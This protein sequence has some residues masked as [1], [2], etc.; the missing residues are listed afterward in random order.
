MDNFERKINKLIK[1][2]EKYKIKLMFHCFFYSILQVFLHHI[3]KSFT[4]F[5]DITFDHWSR[6]NDHQQPYV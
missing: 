4:F 6:K 5:I 1:K 2:K 3:S